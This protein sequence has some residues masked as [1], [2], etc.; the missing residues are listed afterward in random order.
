ME[1]IL[2]GNDWSKLA[3]RLRQE[4]ATTRDQLAQLEAAY[5]T[6]LPLV[7]K[8]RSPKADKGSASATAVDIAMP[9]V[10]R[11]GK[12]RKAKKA[13]LP[14]TGKVLWLAALGSEKS[15]GREI[16]DRALAMLG[17]G[18]E[19]RDPVYTRA[20]TWFNGAVKKGTVV[21]VEQ[22]EG[23]NVYQRAE[24]GSVADT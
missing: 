10:R 18:E 9:P 20:A 6:L 13:A 2:V 24:S 7:A 17:L 14:K 3:G 19:A 23:V 22:R 1:G 12:G 4:I 21:V 5:A 8:G 15:T 11:R 16:V